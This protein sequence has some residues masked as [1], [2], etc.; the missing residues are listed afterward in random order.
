MRLFATLLLIGCWSLAAAPGADAQ[1]FSY[2]EEST[3]ALRAVTAGYQTVGFEYAG[4]EQQVES[5]DF[6]APAYTL[7]LTQPNLLVAVA[8]GD[9][10][11]DPSRG[12]RQLKL[13]DANLFFWGS[14]LSWNGSGHSFFLPLIAHTGYR[15]VDE[16]RTG[17]PALDAFSI[18]TIGLGTG[19]GYRGQWSSSVHAELRATPIGGLALRN[20][21][22]SVGSVRLVD[23]D[24]QLHFPRL[25]G[26]FGV[27]AGYNFRIQNWNVDASELFTDLTDDLFDY[28]NRQHVLRVGINW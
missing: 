27:T 13:V 23:V 22:G 21:E 20:F 11:A 2:S 9:Q 3:R 5:F 8:F 12:L 6:Q 17:T 19:L 25:F 28:R 26:R 24:A 15:R 16:Q 7:T 4:S 18:N 10:A 1:M 14:F